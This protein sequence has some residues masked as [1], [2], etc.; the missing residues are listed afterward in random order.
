MHTT[1]LV[2]EQTDTTVRR[3]ERKSDTGACMCG[4]Q[5][6]NRTGCT[7]GTL[8]QALVPPQTHQHR[9]NY[10]TAT[11]HAERASEGLNKSTLPSCDHTCTATRQHSSAGT[12]NRKPRAPERTQRGPYRTALR[13]YTHQAHQMGQDDLKTYASPSLA[14]APPATADCLQSGAPD[15]HK[16]DC[17]ALAA[18]AA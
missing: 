13:M 12:L 1:P 5:F 8:A 14:S 6:T 11:T 9:H 17:L 15:M 3:P 7:L 2:L 18:T 10:N 16:A 4:D